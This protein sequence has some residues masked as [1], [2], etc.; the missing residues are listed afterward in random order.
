M[1]DLPSGQDWPVIHVCGFLRDDARRLEKELRT[2]PL[3]EVWREHLRET[4]A[5]LE[6]LANDHQADVLREL[7]VG[8][9]G[10]ERQPVVALDVHS[11]QEA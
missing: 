8:L 11:P 4:I 7:Q 1:T 9:H 2:D 10:E 6:R 3:T 5:I